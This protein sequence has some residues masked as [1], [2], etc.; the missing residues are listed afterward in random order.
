MKLFPVM[1]ILAVFPVS[2]QG[3]VADWYRSRNGVDPVITA[4]V[5][6][7]AVSRDFRYEYTVRNGPAAT[8][9]LNTLRLEQVVSASAMFGPPDWE[10]F[11]DATLGSLVGWY[12]AGDPVPGATLV[13]ELDVPSVV[14]E[15][16]PDSALSGF[17]LLSPCAADG[18]VRFYA[19]GYN[20]MS[21]Q[22]P[23][24]TDSSASVPPWR[25]DSATGVVL[26]PGDCTSVHDWGNRRP[27]VDGFV[28]L[29]NNPGN[30]DGLAPDAPVTIQLRF[31]RSG[32][33]VDRATLRVE[34]NRVDVTATFATNSLGDAIA[35]FE[36]GT[37]PLQF[38]RNVLLVSVDGTVPGTNRAATDADRFTFPI[39]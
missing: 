21:V 8:Q 29:V 15:I 28:G 18:A 26:G 19:R 9:R 10:T 1:T 20:H 39:S 37:S 25:E 23:D 27:G 2:T 22:P 38:G 4:R 30:R 7:D 35:V 36:V 5:S 16:P 32:E 24:D 13:S 6:V 3:Q 17:T 11:S 31:S 34:L 12:A 14:S 33:V